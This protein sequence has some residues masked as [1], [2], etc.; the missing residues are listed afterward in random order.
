MNYA[1]QVSSCSNYG[2]KTN[3]T[4]VGHLGGAHSYESG[5]SDY[6][7]DMAQALFDIDLRPD[8]VPPPGRA[9]KNNIRT[10]TIGFADDQ[11]KNDPLLQETAAQG[12]GL[13]DTADD[14]ASLVLAMKKAVDDA[15]SK[16]AA[17]AAVAVVNTQITI[18]NTAYASSYDP[19]Q[20]TGDLEAFRLTPAPASRFSHGS[21]LPNPCSM[22]ALLATATS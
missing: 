18:D 22:G 15:L 19:G 12:G 5:G 16:D 9:K 20:W 11:A 7:D 4:H 6:L 14:T 13:F 3:T 8:L 2:K 10:Y 17:S 21:G 1:G